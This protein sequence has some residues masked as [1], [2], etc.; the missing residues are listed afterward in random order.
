MK[1]KIHFIIAFV[2]FSIQSIHAQDLGIKLQAEEPSYF[3]QKTVNLKKTPSYTAKS[4]II[5]SIEQKG[6]IPYQGHACETSSSS[7]E[8]G[9]NGKSYGSDEYAQI[10][11]KIIQYGPA[12]KQIFNQLKPYDESKRE[13]AEYASSSKTEMDNVGT[14]KSRVILPKDFA[15]GKIVFV[16][17]VIQCTESHYKEYTVIQFRSIALIGTTIINI[18][19]FYNSDDENIAKNIRSEILANIVKNLK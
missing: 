18:D 7:F 10:N 13:L 16:K 5:N 2:F 6:L 3:P 15:D 1:R 4:D 14:R 19:G 8:E 11:L 17:D 9:E 12:G